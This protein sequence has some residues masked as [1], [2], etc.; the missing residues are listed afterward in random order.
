MIIIIIAMVIIIII[1]RIII[2]I[3]TAIY[4]LKKHS[5]GYINT[6]SFSRK[7]LFWFSYKFCKPLLH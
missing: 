1:I 3:I 5:H 7:I 6:K 2:I 4:D